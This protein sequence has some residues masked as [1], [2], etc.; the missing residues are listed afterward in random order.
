M[1]WGLF[2]TQ[3]RRSI[4]KDEGQNI[5]TNPQLLDFL[6]WALDTFCAHTALVTSVSHP[7][8]GVT[9]ALPS[10]VYDDFEFTARCYV[11]EGT[12]WIPVLPESESGVAEGEYAYVRHTPNVLT[13]HR[14]PPANAQFHCQYFAYYALPTA[15]TDVLTVPRWAYPALSYLVG[16]HALASVG[17][18]SANISQWKD[19]MDSGQ[20]EHNALRVQQE[21]FLSLY[22]R[23]LS[24][25]SPQDRRLQWP[26]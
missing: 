7:V 10:D 18:Q 13:L 14:N 25:V 20:P 4:L 21:W 8:T 26:R 16:A 9:V 24:R 12:R 2:R 23:E 11:I 19:K 15:D 22:E 17:V 3:L 1:Q 6:G 5:W